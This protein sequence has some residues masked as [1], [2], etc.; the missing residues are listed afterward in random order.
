MY[1]FQFIMNEIA[2]IRVWTRGLFRPYACVV[3]HCFVFAV[4]VPNRF[5]PCSKFQ[6]MYVVLLIS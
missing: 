6:V 1:V 2:V 3:Y 4:R 5:E